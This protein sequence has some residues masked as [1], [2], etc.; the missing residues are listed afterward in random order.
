MSKSNKKIGYW[1]TL[2][3]MANKLINQGA[4]KD[5]LV[6]VIAFAPEDPRYATTPKALSTPM[7]L[8]EFTKVDKGEVYFVLSALTSDSKIAV[9]A[10]RL[11]KSKKKETHR[12]TFV[13][14]DNK[15]VPLMC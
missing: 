3:V 6:K 2:A 4:R 11:C 8:R 5:S 10:A 12:L 1:D 14:K 7:S 9:G 13:K 15:H